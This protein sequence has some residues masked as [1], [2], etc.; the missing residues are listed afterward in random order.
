MGHSSYHVQ[1]SPAF[2]AL[3]DHA[4][5]LRV[6]ID[7]ARTA[8]L[9]L[10]PVVQEKL[11]VAWTADSNALEGSSLTFGDTLFFL[12]EGLT[13]QGKPFKDFLDARNHADA[14][15]FLFDVVS[16]RRDLTEGVLKEINVMLLAG[17][18]STPAINEQG[19]RIEKPTTP[20]EYKRLSNHVLQPDGK[21]HHYSDPIHVLSEMSALC[22]WIAEQEG[23]T[24][25]ALV[26][27][28]AHY[29]V[30]RIHPFDDGNGRGA[31]IL[32]NLILLR[33]GFPPAIIRNEDRAAYLAALRQADAGSFE[34]FAH[35]T[36]SA[37]ISTEERILYD[38]EAGRPDHADTAQSAAYDPKQS[39]GLSAVSP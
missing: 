30:V 22:R 38:L 11:K 25:P 17:V 24:H 21:I 35:F 13:V 7:A 20:G 3:T 37:L 27:A 5:V 14:I 9:D 39:L 4:D 23:V 19:H 12:K 1:E 29:N 26:A 15:E 10:W 6:R 34:A 18:K 36:L 31:R 33:A 32:M 2:Q 8:R 28:V 16:S